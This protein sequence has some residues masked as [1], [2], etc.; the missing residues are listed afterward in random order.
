MCLGVNGGYFQ[1]GGYNSDH[2]KGKMHHVPLLRSG[3]GGSSVN[4]LIK[5]FGVS[6]NDHRIGGS[7]AITQAFVDSGTTF[8]Y[9]PR[10][11]WD[12]IVAHLDHFCEKSKD[13]RRT[14]GNK[15]YCHG[16][17]FTAMSQGSPVTCFSYDKDYFEGKDGP[18][19]KQFFLGYPV[20]RMHT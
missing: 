19:L 16:D 5:L 6:I 17:R 4:Y 15:K 13:I 1:I 11:M 3:P 20:I 7:G 14:D 2:F 18:S 12:T 9:F 8:S 10:K